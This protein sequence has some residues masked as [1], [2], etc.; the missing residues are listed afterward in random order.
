MHGLVCTHHL[1]GWGG[2]EC[3]TLELID[4]FLLQGNRITLFCPY[5]DSHFIRSSLSSEVA[6][7]Q[8]ANEIELHQ[9]DFVYSHHQMP[10]RFLQFQPSDDL[11]EE[12][13]PVF[14]YNHLSSFEPFEFPGPFC[15]LEFADVLLCNSH[16]TRSK[17][18]EFGPDYANAEIFPNPAPKIFAS[19]TRPKKKENLTRLLAVSNHIPGELDKA[20]VQLG[21]QGIEITRVGHPE[22]NQRLTPEQLLNHDAVVTIGKTV[23][24]ALRSRIPVFCYDWF[25]GPGWLSED[26]F[27]A[28]A[29]VNFS[30]RCSQQ[31]R[32]P[33]NIAKDISLGYRAAHD[34]ALAMSQDQLKPY[35]L[36]GQVAELLDRVKT[37]RTNRR[38]SQPS[39]KNKL[40]KPNLLL[41][42]ELYKLVDRE[43]IAKRRV[44]QSAKSNVV[45]IMEFKFPSN[46]EVKKISTPAAGKAM[47]VAV[48]AYRYDAHLVPALLENISPAVHAWVAWDDRKTCEKFTGDAERRSALYEA[49]RALG[50]DWILAADPDERYEKDLASKI[51]ELTNEHG[52]ICWTFNCREMFGVDQY[53]ID[54]LWHTRPRVRLFPCVAGMGPDAQDLHSSWTKNTAKIPTRSSQLNFYH[55]RMITPR[56]RKHRRSLYAAVDPDRQYQKIGYDYIDD[57]RG[58]ELESIPA[59]REYFPIHSEDNGLWAPEIEDVGQPKNDS[60][61]VQLHRMEATLRVGG[62]GNAAYLAEDIFR[63]YEQDADLG[64][65]ATEM[66]LRAG[67]S[68]ESKSLC[69][70]IN[71]Q[72]ADLVLTDLMLSRSLWHTGNKPDAH[73][74]AQ[75]IAERL[76]QSKTVQHQVSQTLPFPERI[77]HEKASWRQWV[78]Q[79][80]YRIGSNVARSDLCVVVLGY[81]SPPEIVN[82]VASLVSQD[83]IPEIVVVNSGGGEIEALLSDY[84]EQVHLI[85]VEERLFA[86][87]A[88][89]IGVDASSAPYIAFLAS[90]CAAEPGW[91]RHRINRHRLGA[92]AVASA[93][94]P[95]EPEN[96]PSIAAHHLMHW[97]RRPN[98]ESELQTRYG[99]SCTREV[100]ESCGY[101]PTGLRLSE[102]S[103]FNDI[104]RKTVGIGWA[105]EVV[106]T[107]RY[108]TSSNE[109]ISDMKIRGQRRAQYAPFANFKNDEDLKGFTD[110]WS[111]ENI[112]TATESLMGSEN[113]DSKQEEEARKLII[114]ASLADVE[115]VHQGWKTVNTAAELVQKAK[116]AEFDEA[117]EYLEQAIHLWPQNGNNHIQLAQLI[118]QQSSEKGSKLAYRHLQTAFEIAPDNAVAVNAMSD[119]HKANNDMDAVLKLAEEACLLA[120]M[121]V[122]HWWRLNGAANAHGLVPMQIYALQKIVSLIPTNT[123][124]HEKL[125]K[126]HKKAKHALLEECR[127]KFLE[128]LSVDEKQIES[129]GERSAEKLSV[130]SR[131]AA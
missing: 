124:A 52:P 115:G 32:S 113:L 33:A 28:A 38:K 107:H 37:I 42:S 120:P 24:Y 2:S 10:S 116:T 119:I 122:A 12:N 92:S 103:W 100:F 104:L 109:L 77:S 41:E 128:Q 101:F 80:N 68:A 53:R 61:R 129:A 13:R 1:Y 96:I 105:P 71:E 87:A 40:L 11:L 98:P 21:S 106:T 27:D 93:V 78:Q 51:D 49:A 69:E 72:H 44:Q 83:V 95:E 54:G 35:Q 84:I 48:F 59:G 57:D 130:E 5:S 102:D 112:K 14:I 111:K 50:A 25:Q 63:Q 55:L 26:N 74:V 46:I 70:K 88:R 58:M 45:N 29:A 17:L 15:E 18:L 90:D 36:E 86:G 30:G 39:N 89:N 4:E 110:Q 64:L 47:V 94:I 85:M 99:V 9:F 7:V 60:L 3:V 79:A 62:A 91:V 65:L 123:I 125:A 8:N 75:A 117:C 82:A 114:D 121:Q 34:Y 43:Y 127:Y 22:N 67:N 73:L 126:F 20:L 56:R 118:L 23:P 97:R 66:H 81:R 16:E 76:P 108:P 19:L 31:K 6:L 131:K